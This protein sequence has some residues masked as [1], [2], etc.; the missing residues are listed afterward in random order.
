MP[1][2]CGAV[3]LLKKYSVVNVTSARAVLTVHG[4]VQKVF[5]LSTKPKVIL[6]EVI[7]LLNNSINPKTDN[8]D[9]VHSLLPHAPSV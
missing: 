7:T 6:Y 1:E 8:D 3:S 4:L 5:R 9:L 2:I